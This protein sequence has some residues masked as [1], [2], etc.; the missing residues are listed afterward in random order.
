[1]KFAAIYLAYRIILDLPCHPFLLLGL[2]LL[3]LPLDLAVQVGPSSMAHL[4]PRQI[5][6][7]AIYFSIGIRS[8]SPSEKH[9]LILVAVQ[10][11]SILRQSN[12]QN[13]HK[14]GYLQK[15][16]N[17]GCTKMN[18]AK[19]TKLVQNSNLVN[20]VNEQNKGLE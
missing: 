4:L 14:V 15:G 18:H 8:N 17:F 3:F 7:S 6:P 16:L 9:F 20:R 2:N 5:V 13:Q 10:R 19:N 11:K 1:M 12:M